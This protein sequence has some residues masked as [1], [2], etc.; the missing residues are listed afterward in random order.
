[1]SSSSHNFVGDG[2]FELLL[3]GGG[4]LDRE[5]CF[6]CIYFDLSTV[7]LGLGTPA[8]RFFGCYVGC[9]LGKPN[10]AQPG[11]SREKLHPQ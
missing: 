8:S 2:P 3:Q 11:K 5:S 4:H 10:E 6:V 1:M 9:I 7:S